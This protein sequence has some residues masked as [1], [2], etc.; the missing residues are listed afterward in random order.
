MTMRV[1]TQ[2]AFDRGLTTLQRRQGELSSLQEQLTSGKRVSRASDDPA[3][4][5][6][7]ERALATK[8]R[9]EAD[10]RALDASRNVVLQ[11]ESALG[12]A[13]ELLQ[14]V[15]EHVL[16][17]GN[18]SY[19]DAERAGLAQTIRGLREQMLSV[20]NRGD[21]AGGFLFGGQGS[22]E[23]PFVDASGGVQFRGDGGALATANSQ[24]LPL[25]VDGGRAWLQAPDPDTGVDSLSAF[26][27]LDRLA[28]ELATP[29]RSNDQVADTVRIGVRGLDAVMDHLGSTRSQLG[30]SLN[31]ADAVEVRLSQQ[32]LMAAADRSAAEDLDMVQAVSDFQN[33]QTGYDA[34]LKAYSM[35]QR[36]SLFDYVSG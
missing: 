19:S 33:Q 32:A 11:A 28:T 23:V 24:P 31:R 3:A 18:A 5:A 34:A 8:L 4:A 2:N 6:R 15:R 29:G 16:A 22:N 25:S 14:Q 27:V 13:G 35:V 26:D 21:G 17:A 12:D 20:A 36:L 30:E 10:Q 1:S 7:A 9:T